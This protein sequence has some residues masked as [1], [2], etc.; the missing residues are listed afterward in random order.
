MWIKNQKKF[1]KRITPEHISITTDTIEKMY[2]NIQDE[3]TSCFSNSETLQ[4]TCKRISKIKLST[5]KILNQNNEK[6]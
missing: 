6:Y 2:Q 4:K 3:F 5:Y 1:V